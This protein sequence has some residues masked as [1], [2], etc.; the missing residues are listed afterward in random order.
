MPRAAHVELPVRGS[1]EGVYMLLPGVR[2]ARVYS[3]GPLR[4]NPIPLTLPAGPV[5][6]FV[7]YR[8]GRW[9]AGA[10]TLK[11]GPQ[12]IEMPR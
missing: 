1:V 6:L 10:F 5:E 3:P 8:S 12:R 2:A 7:R 11:P 9:S 4:L